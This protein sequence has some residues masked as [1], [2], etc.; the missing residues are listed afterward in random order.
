MKPRFSNTAR[1]FAVLAAFVLASMSM[2][3]SPGYGCYY[4][5]VKVEKASP[6]ERTIQALPQE[7]SEIE[8]EMISE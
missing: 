5:D 2:G 4:S 3:C 7:N 1:G 8:A 6:P